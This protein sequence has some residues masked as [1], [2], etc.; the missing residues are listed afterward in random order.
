MPR[1]MIFRSKPE[2]LIYPELPATRRCVAVIDRSK[3]L[4]SDDEAKPRLASPAL[5]KAWMAFVR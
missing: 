3:R 5:N 4:I 1:A 2:R